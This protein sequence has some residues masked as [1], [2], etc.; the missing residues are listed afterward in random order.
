MNRR[1]EIEPRPAELGGGWRLRLLATEP[2]RE[3]TERGGGGF[4]PEPEQGIGADDAYAGTLQTGEDWLA[5]FVEN[6]A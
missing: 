3:E 1:F 4:P 5:F 6:Q 2:G